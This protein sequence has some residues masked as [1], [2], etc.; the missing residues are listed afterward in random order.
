M[1][2][3]KIYSIPARFRKIENLHILFWLLKDACWALNFKYPALFM[4]LPTLIAAF[5]IAWQTRKLFSEFVHNLAVVFWIVANCTWMIGE[6][7]GLDEGRWGLRNMALLPFGMGLLILGG[8]YFLY[9]T[10]RSFKEKILRQ[11]EQLFDP[12]QGSDTRES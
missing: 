10:N 8:Y 11:T 12:L 1:K 9:L 7:F 3:K 2:D 6:F 5:F 4:I